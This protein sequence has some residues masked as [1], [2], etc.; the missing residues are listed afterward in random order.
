MTMSIKNVNWNRVFF[1][2][3]KDRKKKFKKALKSNLI[4]FGIA[5]VLLLVFMGFRW[6]YA[7]NVIDR[8]ALES[9][10]DQIAP[11]ELTIE[12]TAVT[13]DATVSGTTVESSVTAT[14]STSVADKA[15][16]SWSDINF[17][18][19]PD[20]TLAVE[21]NGGIPYFTD[22]ELSLE[23]FEEYSDLDSYGR[24]GVAFACLTQDMMPGYDAE[25]GDI[26]EVKPSGWKSIPAEDVDKGWLYNRSH[27]IAWALTG[28]DDNPKNLV[29]GTRQFN[30]DA[31]LPNEIAVEEVLDDNPGLHIMYRVTPVFLDDEL[32]CRGVIMEAFSVEDNGSAICYCFFVPNLQSGWTIDYKTGYAER[33]ET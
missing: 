24:C 27:L 14:S 33:N 26:S 22:D 23:S 11:S 17:E 2:E 16:F 30:N 20:D 8:N 9:Q 21:L 12:T 19:L 5:L 29:T 28:Q 25:R 1:G 6:A 4:E 32:V 31:M 10:F 15:H 18:T 13:S 3:K 7:N